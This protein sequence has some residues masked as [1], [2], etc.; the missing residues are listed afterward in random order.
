MRTTLAALVIIPALVPRIRVAV[1]GT[2]PVI[3]IICAISSG[4]IGLM[5]AYPK[6]IRPY[7][8]CGLYGVVVVLDSTNRKS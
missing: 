8:R 4:R 1:L 2:I 3:L 6:L 5:K 7:C